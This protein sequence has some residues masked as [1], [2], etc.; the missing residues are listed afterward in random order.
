MKSLL[1]LGCLG[2]VL[3]AACGP[4]PPGWIKGNLPSSHQNYLTGV[5][6][7]STPERAEERAKTTLIENLEATLAAKDEFNADW[8]PEAMRQLRKKIEIA[9]R[10]QDENRVYALAVLERDLAAAP[11]HDVLKSLDARIDEKVHEGDRADTSLARLDHYRGVLDL[12]RKRRALAGDLRL[13]QPDATL[14]EAA[15]D[16][17]RIHE[18]IKASVE[19]LTFDLHVQGEGEETARIALARSLAKAGMRLAPSWDRELLVRVAVDGTECMQE[20][21]GHRC[22]GEAEADLVDRGG[23]LFETVRANAQE[24]APVPIRARE[25]VLEKLGSLLAANILEHLQE[26]AGPREK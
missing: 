21:S 25:N 19:N 4:Q 18:K 17:A 1:W 20:G 26:P 12:L 5:G 3:L 11:L 8:L 15:Y 14:G 7:A 23:N 9:D 13:F 6:S 16:D 24:F 22:I 10:W 2:F